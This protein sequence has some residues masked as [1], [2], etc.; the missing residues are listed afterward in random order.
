MV[1]R[2]GRCFGGGVEGKEEARMEVLWK[3][4]WGERVS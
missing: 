1:C 2:S 4:W 3:G